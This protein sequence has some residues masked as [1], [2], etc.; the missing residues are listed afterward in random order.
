MKR[1]KTNEEDEA[2]ERVSKLPSEI[3][4]DILSRVPISSLVQFQYVS[5][6]CRSVA[7]DPQMVKYLSGIIDNNLCLIFHSGIPLRDNLYFVNYPSHHIED[8]QVKRICPPFSGSMPEFNIVGSCNGILCLSDNYFQ[9]ELILYNPFTHYVK[10]LLESPGYQN[11]VAVYGFGFHKETNE[12]KLVKVIQ[13]RRT[14]YNYF[15][16][17]K[18]LEPRVQVLIVGKSKWIDLG[19]PDCITARLVNWSS[20]VLASE[21]IHWVAYGSESGERHIISFCL[22]NEKLEKVEKPD[23]DFLK[24]RH[25]N[26]LSIRDCL[27]AA[28]YCNYGRIE[29]WVRRGYNDVQDLRPT[30]VNEFFIRKYIPWGMRSSA[31]SPQERGVKVLCV[32]KNGKILFEYKGRDIVTYDRHSRRFKRLLFQGMPSQFKAILHVGCFNWID[33]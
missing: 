28:F 4:S 2:Q 5:P 13:P 25:F 19:K 30:W 32:L 15:G 33:T 6:A 20:Q 7:R 24:K 11:Q 16:S 12:Y 9:N 18:K 26:L 10:K 27:A 8:E 23:S 31:V 21:R 14:V 1:S 17:R 3:L 29:I 22:A